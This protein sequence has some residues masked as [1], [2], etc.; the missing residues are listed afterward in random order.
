MPSN[1][2]PAPYTGSANRPL[3]DDG[4]SHLIAIAMDRSGLPISLFTA[5]RWVTGETF[6]TAAAAVAMLDKFEIDH[7]YPCLATNRWITALLR[8]FR[9]QIEVLLHQRDAAIQDW[10]RRYP[11][12]DVFEDRRLEITSELLIDIDEQIARVDAA[13]KQHFVAGDS[14]DRACGVLA[15]RGP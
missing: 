9:P 8:L 4:I 6:Y 5:N 3:G 11:D 7:A 12:G 15:P 2:E 1:V 10:Q 13:L 14:P